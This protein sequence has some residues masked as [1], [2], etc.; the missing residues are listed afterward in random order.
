MPLSNAQL[1][2]FLDVGYLA[3]PLDLP[4]SLHDELFRSAQAVYAAPA[5]GKGFESR[6]ARMADAGLVESCPALNRLLEAPQLDDALSSVLGERYYRYSHAF[7]HKAG[8]KDQDYHKDSHLPWS[9]RGAVRSHRPQWAM[10]FYYPQDTTVELGATRV[11][12]GTQYWNVDHEIEGF[13]QGEDRLGLNA[14]P[15]PADETNEAADARLATRPREL[16]PRC[17]SVALEV[18]KGSLLLVNFDLFHRG[19]RTLKSG[20]RFMYKFW[21]CRTLEPRPRAPIPLTS[22]D[23]RRLPAV[24]AVASWLTSQRHEV[25]VTPANGTSEAGRVAMAYTGRDPAQICEDLL[26]ECEAV[27][28][29]A[30]YGATVLGEGAVAAALAATSSAHWGVR[31]SGAFVLGELAIDTA[32]VRDALERLTSPEERPDVRCTAVVALGRIGR[33]AVARGDG[34]AMKTFAR[35]LAPLA[36]PTREP[37]LPKR[38]MPGNPVRQN[39]ALA[40]LSLASEAL[41]GGSTDLSTL[42]ETA[43]TMAEWDTDRYARATSKEVVR[44]IVAATSD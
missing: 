3:I 22:E 2:Q 42:T 41:E 32:P 16:D 25:G 4:E 26:D 28:R 33:A 37:D 36:N 9:M 44:R 38:A 30:M 21:Y 12:P 18:P 24:S 17:E 29:P 14:A 34:A 20:D 7:V 40:L 39:L 8:P 1:A 19:A 43:A 6:I 15:V 5:E 23:E 11:M 10:T 13:E 31:K 27:R 35:L